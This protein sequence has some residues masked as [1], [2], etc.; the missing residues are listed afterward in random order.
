MYIY[1]NIWI[2]HFKELLSLTLFWLRGGGGRSG[3][4]YLFL[5]DLKF[6]GL[7]NYHMILTFSVERGVVIKNK[8]NFDNE[9]NLD[10]EKNLDN[11]L[12]FAWEMHSFRKKKSWTNDLY[13]SEKW[14]NYSFF[15]WTNDFLEQF[16]E[17]DFIEQKILVNKQFYWT[18]SGK[19]HEKDWNE[20]YFLNVQ[21][22]FFG[23]I[24][25][26][27]LQRYVINKVAKPIVIPF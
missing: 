12:N 13:H 7:S 24:E 6:S 16:L 21:F 2:A 1:T 4:P 22:S 5:Q 17:F 15:Y 11:K 10:N 27:K 20:Q 25:T 26:R 3:H 19:K 14:K 23:M 18:I 8:Q 9:Q